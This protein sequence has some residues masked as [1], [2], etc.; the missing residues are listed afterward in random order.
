MR[1]FVIQR[2][3]RQLRLAPQILALRTRSVQMR[4]ENSGCFWPRRQSIPGFP[5]FAF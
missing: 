3:E 4:A 1:V 2:P 5:G